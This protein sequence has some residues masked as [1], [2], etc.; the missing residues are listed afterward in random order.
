MLPP[1]YFQ[2]QADVLAHTEPST[3]ETEGAK[4]PI[5]PIYRIV[6]DTVM[7]SV[8]K[9]ILICRECVQGHNPPH[10]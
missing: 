6:I 5:D 3:A 8:I 1:C 2:R 10:P 7:N 4:A 9:L